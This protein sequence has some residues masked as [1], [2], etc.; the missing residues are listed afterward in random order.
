MQAFQEY[1]QSVYGKRWPDL[2][3][4]L[5]NS[6]LQSP[7]R[8]LYS[9]S[10]VEWNG[11]GQI[12]RDQEGLLSY[13][14][15]DPASQIAARALE[16]QEGDVVL[17]M[18]AAPGGKSLILA[19]ARPQQLIL[20]ELSA[21]RRERLKKVLQQYIP[22]DQREHIRM[23]GK[24]GGL[25]AKTHAGLF[26]RILLDAP[27]SGERHLAHHPT[28]LA[29][30]SEKGSQKLA[31]RQYALL[32]AA[33]IAA[34]PEGHI[35]YSTCSIS[36]HENDG[37]IQELLVRKGERFDIESLPQSLTPQA[38]KTKFGYIYLP[39]KTFGGPIYFCRLR[40]RPERLL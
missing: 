10:A 3:A 18:C 27:C 38:E 6:E 30:W 9:K 1:F 40:V 11:Q 20:N 36:P 39:D 33:L 14:V 12:P 24:D 35:L 5:L 19:E 15:M 16:V 23:T 28:D 34:K 31:R 26:N 29:N 17:D 32:T 37:V 21:P 7:R 8:S 13:Y 2:W 25:F 4:A 22:R